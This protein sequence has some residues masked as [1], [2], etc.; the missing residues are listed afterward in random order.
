MTIQSFIKILP[1][2][3]VFS[4]GLLKAQVVP[5]RW[6]KVDALEQGT[7]IIITMKSGERV[8]GAFQQHDAEILFVAE[9]N[10]S[11]RPIPER[12]VAKV[13]RPLV[14][15]DSSWDGAAIGAAIGYG[16]GWAGLAAMKSG[17]GDWAWSDAFEMFGPIGAAVGFGIGFA[18]DRA[19]KGHKGTE[20]LYQSP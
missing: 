20:L 8:D 14:E 6:E 1:L 17:G 12:D 10:G 16:G 5:G 11:E 15:G 3:V 2:L 19:H 13:V 18:I 7:E 4:S 9:V